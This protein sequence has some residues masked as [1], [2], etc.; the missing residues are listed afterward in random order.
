MPYSYANIPARVVGTGSYLPEK[1]VHN[2][3][4]PGLERTNGAVERLLGA[5]ER[6]AAHEDQICSDIIVA[7]ARKILESSEVLPQDLDRIIV[8]ATPGDYFEPCTASVVQHKLGAHCPA[9]DVGMSCV[10]WLAG[11]DYALR[12]I[13]TGEQRVLVLAGTIVSRGTPFYNP[14]HRAIFGD[15]A[16]GVLLEANAKPHFLSGAL[17]TDGQYH[18]VI[19]M[20]HRSSVHSPRIPSEYRGS[21]FMGERRVINQALRENLAHGVEAVLQTAGLTRDD[22]DVA[23]IHQ[24]SKPLYE[25]AVKAVGMPREKLIEDYARYGNTISAEL[26]ISLDESVRTGRVKRGDTILKVTFGA[27]FSGGLMVYRY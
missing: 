15:G 18:D 8:S 24:P 26:P 1:I 6:R 16:G 17:W 7:A 22:I 13:A 12:C 4:I 27:G 3:D 19:T 5:V 2:H 14:M 21:F 23:F 20:P 10:G 25:E 9:V 11:V